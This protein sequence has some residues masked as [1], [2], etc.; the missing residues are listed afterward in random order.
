MKNNKIKVVMVTNHFEI[1]GIGTVIMNYCKELNKD[2]YDLAILAGQPISDK[3]KK[4]CKEY[5]IHLI[6]LPSRHGEPLKHYWKLW[7]ALKIGKYDVFHDHG[8]SS[9]MAIELTIAKLAGIKI[10]IAHCH[11]STCPNMMAHRILNSYFKTLYTK[12]L[13]CGKLAGDW[14]FGKANFEVLPNG[15][16][17]NNFEFSQKNRDAVR[18]ALN[19]DNQF[20]IGHIGRI[21]E[22]KNQEYLLK[23]FEKVADKKKDALLLIVG[24]GPDA[25]KIKAQVKVHPYKERIILYGETENPTAFYSAMDV[26]AFPSRFEGLPVVLLE[27]QISGLPCIVSDKVTQEVNLGDISWQSIDMDPE[28]WANAVLKIEKRSGKD[29]IA[30]NDEHLI[31]IEKYDIDESVKQLDSIYTNLLSRKRQ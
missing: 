17:T 3:Y 25:E 15:F 16:H 22:Q 26:F 18:S 14:I 5:G 31:Q 13:A 28:E 29:R 10:R 23:I 8:N 6:E 19:I 27:A 1:T 11:N 4:G 21:N 12:A 30:Y 2:K 24:T 9:M 20:V 7:K